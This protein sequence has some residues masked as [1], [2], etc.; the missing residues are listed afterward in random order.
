MQSGSIY[1]LSGEDLTFPAAEVKALI[2][3]YA[4]EK[5]C[6]ILGARVIVSSVSDPQVIYKVTSRAA[7]CR[8]GGAF[9][10]SGDSKED[11]TSLDPGIIEDGKTFAVA[12][13]TLEREE[14]G[15]LGAKI[16]SLTNARVSLESPDYLFQVEK[17]TSG[18]ALGV[19]RS[20][21]KKTSWRER[22]PRAR[23]FFLP[24]AIYP[25]L[26]ALLVN[27]SRVKEG[28][29]FLDAF[30]GTGSL[31]IES[32]IMGM[33]AV[34]IDIVKWITR[35]ANSN[36]RGFDLQSFILRGDST[37][38]L[39]LKTVHGV[40]TD[41]PYGRAAST[42]GKDTASILREFTNALCDILPCG[43][44][45]VIMH[46]SHVELEFESKSFQVE[47]RHLLYVHRNLT[48]AISVLRRI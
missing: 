28:E 6:E 39:P 36:M 3:T 23:K 16:K 9:V 44:C 46:P 26:A 42:R 7:Y 34:G 20:G 22:R 27:L 19:N 47:E 38:K 31:L 14:C 21:Y 29:V 48:R 4:P 11:L 1:V 32:S 33:D 43:R 15:D 5:S 13:E 41:V 25:K 8:F 30:C 37:S 17:I 45:A 24:S 10:S 18:Y 35:G 2:E 40:A 12:S